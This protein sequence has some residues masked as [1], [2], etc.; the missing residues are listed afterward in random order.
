MLLKLKRARS[1]RHER[2]DEFNLQTSKIVSEPVVNRYEP[3]S[4]PV[5]ADI[6][7]NSNDNFGTRQL[8]VIDDIPPIPEPK[9]RRKTMSDRSRSQV[10]EKQRSIGRTI[11]RLLYLKKTQ[12]HVA[13]ISSTATIKNYSSAIHFCNRRSRRATPKAVPGKVK[14]MARARKR[15][16]HVQASWTTS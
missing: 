6:T 16:A 2:A 1:T 15:R 8:R 4:V 13:D 7:Q 5:K 3:V 9:C 10:K 14:T 12:Q 11:S